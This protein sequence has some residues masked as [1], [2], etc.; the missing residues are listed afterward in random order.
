VQGTKKQHCCATGQLIEI[1]QIIKSSLFWPMAD[2]RLRP[3]L[4]HWPQRAKP[5][6]DKLGTPPSGADNCSPKGFALLASSF[7]ILLV[8]SLGRRAMKSPGF[9]AT[10]DQ[11][12]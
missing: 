3:A 5:S 10:P 2:G 9:K 11:S 4:K 1:I 12:G 8:Y 7:R 6:L